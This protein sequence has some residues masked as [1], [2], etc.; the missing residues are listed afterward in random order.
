[1]KVPLTLARTGKSSLQPR[2]L[3]PASQCR[4]DKQSEILPVKIQGL[5]S[6]SYSTFIAMKKPGYLRN[7]DQLY[8]AHT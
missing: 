5:A 4:Q 1:M 8:L 2:P 7:E 3:R 6:G